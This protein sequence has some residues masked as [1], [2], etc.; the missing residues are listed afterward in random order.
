MFVVE[1]FNSSEAEKRN[2]VLKGA[3]PKVDT[4]KKDSPDV[5]AGGGEGGTDGITCIFILPI[6]NGSIS[7]R[8]PQSI[9]TG[10]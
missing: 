9:A 10:Q 4:E 2:P 1:E 3:Q 6:A 5:P 7:R 8:S